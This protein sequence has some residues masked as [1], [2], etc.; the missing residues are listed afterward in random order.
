MWNERMGMGEFIN[1]I[2]ERERGGIATTP[3]VRQ[4][5]WSLRVLRVRGLRWQLCCP[6]SLIVVKPS[7][8][9]R[10]PMTVW[11]RTRS[12]CVQKASYIQIAVGHGC[13]PSIISRREASRFFG[14]GRKPHLQ[15]GNTQLRL[16]LWSSEM[17]TLFRA[18]P[19]TTSGL[20]Y[21]SVWGGSSWGQF[22]LAVPWVALVADSSTERDLRW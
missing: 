6:V 7:G 1:D 13:F 17:M 14:R 10:G 5:P 8:R 22:E 2:R 11:F 9:F 4:T 21:V 15:L 19:A 18:R 3:F 20:G 16:L 12:R